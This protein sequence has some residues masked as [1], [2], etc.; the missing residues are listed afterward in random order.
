MLTKLIRAFAL[1]HSGVDCRS[2]GDSV[3]RKDAFG[4]SEGVCGSCR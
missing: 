3:G 2:C 4:L 1:Q